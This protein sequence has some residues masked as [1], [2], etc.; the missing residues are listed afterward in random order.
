MFQLIDQSIAAHI[1]E[2]V[3]DV[4][5]TLYDPYTEEGQLTDTARYNMKFITIKCTDP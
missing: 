3:V 4:L 2:I 5:M 1:E